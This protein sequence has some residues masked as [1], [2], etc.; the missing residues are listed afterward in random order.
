MLIA[1]VKKEKRV[2][3]VYNWKDYIPME[4]YNDFS[5]ETG[6]KIIEKTYISDEEMYQKIKEGKEHFDIVVPAQN[7]LSILKEEGLIRKIDSQ[8]IKTYKNI[9]P[10]VLERLKKVD[11]TNEYGVPFSLGI[12][13]IVVNEKYVKNYNGDYDIFLRKD[14]KNK[15]QMVGEKREILAIALKSL[16]YEQDTSNDKE[17]E[18]ASKLIIKWKENNVAFNNLNYAERFEIEEFYVSSG[19]VDDFYLNKSDE[20][21]KNIK[22]FIPKKGG[23]GYIDSFSILT[24]SEN[25]DEAYEFIEYIHKP[26]VYAKIFSRGNAGELLN[27]K[28]RE[29]IKKKPLYTIEEIKNIEF[30]ENLEVVWN[31]QKKYLEKTRI[32]VD[33]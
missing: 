5:K 28:S 11:P 31:Y 22:F 14:L 15:L 12:T 24:T 27:I 18:A 2:L 13:G 23:L 19:Y 10:V 9:D 7:Y 17:L 20:E 16:G 3:Y 4:V 33:E 1:C 26:E 25:T 32:K 8:K 21:V 30:L 6:I 29:L